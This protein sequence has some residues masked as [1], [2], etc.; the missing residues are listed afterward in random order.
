MGMDDTAYTYTKDR[1]MVETLRNFVKGET[2]AE[3]ET[4]AKTLQPN[5]E[6]GK[7]LTLDTEG[8]LESVNPGSIKGEP[9]ENHTD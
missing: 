5:G 8:T 1:M 3:A 6:Y 4:K 9:S 2:V 7:F